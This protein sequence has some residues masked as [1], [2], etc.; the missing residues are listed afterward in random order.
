VREPGGATHTSLRHAFTMARPPFV[1]RHTD[2]GHGRSA[3]PISRPQPSSP[4]STSWF[5]AGVDQTELAGVDQVGEVL[6]PAE[7]NRCGDGGG[8][9]R[10]RGRSTDRRVQRRA[11]RWGDRGRSNLGRT[12]LPNRQA[13][14][15]L[16]HPAHSLPEQLP[17]GL[18]LGVLA[19][20]EAGLI[21]FVV[22]PMADPECD[23][24]RNSRSRNPRGTDC[25]SSRP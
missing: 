16:S 11:A 8:R 6:E 9:G 20:G 24:Y 15:R 13:R 4:A 1:P 10:A 25:D 3:P 5:A 14:P 22:A 17:P 18:V 2:A 7:R 23:K 21:L 19:K 12:D